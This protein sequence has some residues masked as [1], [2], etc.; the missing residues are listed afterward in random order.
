MYSRLAA[1]TALALVLSLPAQAQDTTAPAA[2]TV[3]A[4]VNGVDITL[5]HMIVLRSGLPQQYQQLPDDVLFD[6]VLEQLVRQTVLAQSY[7]G[8]SPLIELELDNTRRALEA[9]E[10][11]AEVATAAVTDEA[12]QAAYDA[13]IADMGAVMEF[14]ASH[15]LVETEEKAAELIAE[16]AGGADFAELAK[17]H[18][19][20]P[21]GPNGG[22][23]NWF[24]PEMMVAPFAEAV[25]ALE[26]GAVSAAPVQTQFG[27]HVIKL[28]DTR[29]KPAPS[30]DEL[31]GQL[32]ETLQQEAVGAEIDR[33]MAGADVVRPDL[34]GLDRSALSDF[35][36]IQN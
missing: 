26:V 5:G 18:S 33:L 9:N 34:S 10:I 2:D 27:W 23:L 1:A 15:I 11:I 3:V 19:T 28:N 35:S 4:T 32:S 20:G 25:R 12:L 7:E 36:L 31:R 29:E 24:E 14:N 6:G 8:G 30:L 21:T 17:A 16:L 22:N 13:A